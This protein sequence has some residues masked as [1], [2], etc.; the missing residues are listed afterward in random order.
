MPAPA[1]TLCLPSQGLSRSHGELTGERDTLSQQQGEHV[2]RILE[3]EGDIQAISD[4]V[5]MKEVELDR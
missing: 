3:L 1:L 5:L 2:A 4:K